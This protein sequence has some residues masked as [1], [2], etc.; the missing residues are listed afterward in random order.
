MTLH[1]QRSGVQSQLVAS[2]RPLASGTFYAFH[3]LI[4]HKTLFSRS[5]PFPWRRW[6]G[7]SGRAGGAIQLLLQLPAQCLGCVRALS[8]LFSGLRREECIGALD[9][10]YLER[11]LSR[12]C[13]HMCVRC[14]ARMKSRCMKLRRERT[15]E[16]APAQVADK[17]LHARAASESIASLALG[18]ARTHTRTR[19]HV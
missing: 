14:L 7:S 6:A 18:L 2:A 10:S 12:V 17:S 5:H 13:L 1:V 4:V 11:V 15:R 8:L 16:Q 3:S 19:M 9:A